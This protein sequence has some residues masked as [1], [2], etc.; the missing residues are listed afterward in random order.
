MPAPRR[1]IHSVS[2]SLVSLLLAGGMA[3]SLVACNET[4]LP[5]SALLPATKADLA[6]Q[7]VKRIAIGDIQT[8][9]QAGALALGEDLRASLVDLQRFEILDRAAT[10]ALLQ[11][12][13]FNASG[14]VD[15]STTAATGKMTGATV[16]VMGSLT[17]YGF[18][19][20]LRTQSQTAT[21]GKVYTFYQRVNSAA[22]EAS[23]KLIDIE[24]GKLIAVAPCTAQMTEVIPSHTTR[25]LF[26]DTPAE[27][28]GEWTSEQP[29][30]PDE[31]TYLQQVRK[32]AVEKFVHQIA[33]YSVSF[34]VM[35]EDDSGV[36]TLQAGVKSAQVGE[37]ADAEASFLAATQ[38]KPTSAA[39]FYNLGI[40][41]RSLGKFDAAIA[42][43]KA[44]FKLDQQKKYQADIALTKSM[45]AGDSQK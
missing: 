38:A 34:D 21:D 22:I 39:A 45:Q 13:K 4:R 16:L 30:E 20:K 14:L 31:S 9:D 8:V 23:F 35:L 36:P 19:T 40:A 10:A 32:V 17:K 1:S 41:Q 2:A 29:A 43:F 18:T 7:G 37:W 3:F 26:L 6:K 5:V 44:A 15:E 28:R 24:T 11:E 27:T 33:P 12:H 25:N 42:S